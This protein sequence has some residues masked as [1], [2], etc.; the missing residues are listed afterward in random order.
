MTNKT[1]IER[2]TEFMKF[3]S[4]MNQLFVIAALEVYAKQVINKKE[5]FIEFY[6]D[7]P[8]SGEDFVEAAV[9]WIN[10]Q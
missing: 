10:S 4:P 9:N 7:S 1:N 6:K 2:V 5:K 3:G 8:I